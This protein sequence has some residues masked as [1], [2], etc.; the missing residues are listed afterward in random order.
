M[1][2]KHFSFIAIMI[3]AMIATLAVFIDTELKI[4]KMEVEVRE[5]RE[6]K[7]GLEIE[8]TNLKEKLRIEIIPEVIDCEKEIREGDIKVEIK[9]KMYN[10]FGEWTEITEDNVEYQLKYGGRI[11]SCLEDGGDIK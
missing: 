8:N 1:E 10:P 5:L 11:I 4:G 6:K 2:K 3:I 9:M 7:Q